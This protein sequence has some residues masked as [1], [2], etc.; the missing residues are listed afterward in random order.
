MSFDSSKTTIKECTPP[1]GDL[2]SVG[3]LL[4]GYASEHMQST[5]AY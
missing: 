2:S 4:K 3:A 1:V 5:E